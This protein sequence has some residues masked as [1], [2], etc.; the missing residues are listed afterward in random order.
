MASTSQ[1]PG[2]ELERLSQEIQELRRELQRER[3]HHPEDDDPFRLSVLA[4]TAGVLALAAFTTFLIAVLATAMPLWV[5]AL[6]VAV[7]Y[8]PIAL[9]LRASVRRSR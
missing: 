5:A 9:A 8:A 1:E 6:I 4:T 7:F 3:R 2:R